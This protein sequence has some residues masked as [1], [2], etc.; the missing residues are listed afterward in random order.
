MPITKLTFTVAV[1][2]TNENRRLTELEV[3][4]ELRDQVAAHIEEHLSHAEAGLMNLDIPI[5]GA[6]T[7][8]L[9]GYDIETDE[10]EDDETEPE[11]TVTPEG[12]KRRH[13]D[14]F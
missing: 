13:P 3:E 14:S 9:E 4:R 10:E 8:T 7:I 5:D 2:I 6:A 12:P 1:C 11:V